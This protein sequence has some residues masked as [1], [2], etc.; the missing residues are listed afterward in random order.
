MCFIG[1]IGIMHVYTVLLYTLSVYWLIL[2]LINIYQTWKSLL[3]S[4]FYTIFIYDKNIFCHFEKKLYFYDLLSFKFFFF[5]IR[6]TI[7]WCTYQYFSFIFHS[8]IFSPVF[9]Y[10]YIYEKVEFQMSNYK[11]SGILWLND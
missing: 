4:N 7:I 3:K 8:R 10:R 6:Y 11:G 1:Y 2:L 5:E 9:Q